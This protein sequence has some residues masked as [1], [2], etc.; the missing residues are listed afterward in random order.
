MAASRGKKTGP[1]R[2]SKAPVYRRSLQSAPTPDRYRQIQEAL[3]AKGH[4]AGTPNGSWG[5]D[6]V[7]ALKRFQQEQSLEPTGKIN[8]LSLIALGLGPKHEKVAVLP[9]APSESSPSG[10]R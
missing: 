4:F 5:A 3:Q 8:S 7:D 9:P 1:V 6:S 2:R 10:A